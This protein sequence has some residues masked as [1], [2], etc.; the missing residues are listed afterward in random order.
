MKKRSKVNKIFYMAVLFLALALCGSLKTEAASPTGKIVMSVEKFTIGQGYLL[1]P[2]EVPIYANEKASDVFERVMTQQGYRYGTGTS[3]FWYLTGIKNADNGTLNIP[4]CVRTLN[5]DLFEANEDKNLDEFDF[6]TDSG[7][8]YCVNDDFLNVGA[9]DY[10]VKNGDVIRWRYTVSKGDLGS[11]LSLPN[12]DLLTRSMALFNANETLCKKKGYQSAY[13]NAKAYITDMDAYYID[14]NK[15]GH[16]EEEVSAKVK[17]LCNSLPSET[18]INTWKVQEQEAAKKAAEQEAAAQKEAARKAELARAKK[19][20]PCAPKWKSIKAVKG[21]KAS[22]KWEKNKK[23]TGYQI[24]MSTKKSSGY[25]K[26]STLK[27]WKKVTYTKK[28]LKKKKKYYF[29]IRAY[30]KAEGKTYYSSYS[31]VKQIK[32][33]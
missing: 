22:L 11:K 23:A 21:G 3:K 25:K 12:L 26:I 20:T 32:A 16:S 5:D 13:N 19:Y 14:E 33:K 7:W 18:M 1:E 8:M 30:K 2:C 29:K 10:T 28:K 24:Y 9:K 27:S 17:S 6:T 15:A 4:L 31:K